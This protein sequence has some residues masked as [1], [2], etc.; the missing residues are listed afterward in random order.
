LSLEEGWYLMSTPDLERELARFR[1]AD[2]PPSGAVPLSIEEALARRAAGNV[3]DS[4]GR[5]LRLVLHI[6]G[7]G[8]LAALDSKRLLYEPDYHD[9]PNWRKPGSKPVNVVPLRRRGVAPLTADAWWERPELKALE[10]E[11]SRS[12]T[13]L[14]VVVPAAYRGFVYK[15][16]L[17][18]R[19]AG[20]EITAET[21][22]DS[23]SRWVPAREAESIRAALLDANPRPPIA[24][25]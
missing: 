13:V 15:T 2:L 7:A 18:L 20:I 8:D 23:I 11:W 21:L 14:G 10:D 12:G 17:S 9:P 6:A 16:A 5:T 24:D 4:E 25:C 1:G 3:P 22:V 19:A